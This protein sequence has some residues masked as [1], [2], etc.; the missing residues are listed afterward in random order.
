MIRFVLRDYTHVFPHSLAVNWPQGGEIDT[1]E[2]VNLQTMNQMS[3]HTETVR[4]LYP[5]QTVSHTCYL[6]GCMQVSPNETSTLVSGTNCSHI[7]NDDQ[8]CAVLDPSTASF[9][10]GFANASGGTF[11][12][13]F[14]TT[15]IRH[16]SY[17]ETVYLFLTVL[18][19]YGSSQW[20]VHFSGPQATDPDHPAFPNTKCVVK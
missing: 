10:A 3:L 15:G 17:V 2:G 16:V 5:V 6:Q 7:A 4:T 20:V 19:V 8:G 1:F 12:T 11:V 18:A 13:E 14:A 9:G